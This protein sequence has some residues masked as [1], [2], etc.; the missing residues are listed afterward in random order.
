MSHFAVSDRKRVYLDYSA[1]APIDS[2]VL[3]T[4][5]PYFDRRFCN[6]SSLHENG[7]RSRE[8]IEAARAR[9]AE[10]IGAR[11]QE[12]IF[13]G[14]GTESDNLALFGAARANRARGDHIIISAV[15]HKAVL[16]AAEALAKEG[17]QITV[18]P[19][20]SYGRIDVGKCLAAVTEKTILISLMYVN[21]ELGTVEP[22][23]ELAEALKARRRGKF[24]LLH[25]DACQASNLFSLNVKE[26]GVD[27]MTVNSSKIY[28]PTGVGLL[29][30]RDGV[31]LLPVIVGGEQEKNLRGGTENVPFIIGF[32]EALRK[33]QAGREAEYARLAELRKYFVTELTERV[34]GIIIN[35]DPRAQA[36]SIAHITIPFV[37]G[38]S[39]LLR[40]DAKGISVSTGSACSAFDLRPSHVLLAIGQNP[41]LVHGSIRFS[42]GKHTTKNELDYV[43]EVFPKIVH[44]LH[45]MS[46]L[47]LSPIYL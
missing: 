8:A 36:P 20:N 12:I 17:F 31:A 22:V 16:H 1:M 34:P 30:I 25:T 18:L 32:A 47:T 27:L 28:G 35:G 41:E 11:P 26:L 14:S 6:P 37:E 3:R 24:P 7:R 42:L 39:M 23:R 21:N 33:A 19:V 46:A 13:T 9:V 4:M 2:A 40:L 5:L 43:L 15:E 45:S 44:N 29:Y 10:T 38:E